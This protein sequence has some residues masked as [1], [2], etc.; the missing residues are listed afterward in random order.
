MKSIISRVYIYPSGPIVAKIVIMHYYDRE[1]HLNHNRTLSQQ[2][3]S[4]RDERI[5]AYMHVLH[6]P[7]SG[8]PIVI[9]YQIDTPSWT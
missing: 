9:M 5:R 4:V 1:R 7:K 8:T 3:V 2:S 6:R